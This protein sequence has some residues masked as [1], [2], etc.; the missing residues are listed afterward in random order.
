MRKSKQKGGSQAERVGQGKEEGE[1]FNLLKKG[2]S[3]GN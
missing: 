3:L 1:V 2:S